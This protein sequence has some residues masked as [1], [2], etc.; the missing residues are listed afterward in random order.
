MAGSESYKWD[1]KPRFRRGAFGPRSAKAVERVKQAVAEI[2]LVARREPVLAAEGAVAF[3]E[4]VSAALEYVD[5]SSGAIGTAVNKAIDEL[6]PIISAAPVEN[7]TRQAWLER[8]FSAHEMEDIPYIDLLAERWGELCASPELAS[9]WADETLPLTREVVKPGRR[10]GDFYHGDEICLS[11]LFF[12]GRYQEIVD[13]VGDDCYWSCRRWV[14]R[15]LV[16]LG[17]KAEAIRYAET[18][19]GPYSPGGA[20]DG[21]CEGVL[22]SS[23]LVEEAYRRYGLT[24]NG[25]QTNLATFRAVAKK[26][27]HKAPATI[28]ADLATTTP[29]TEGKWFAAA[30]SARLYDLALDLARRSA[31]DLRVMARA[32]RDHK[33]AQPAFALGA[34]MLA[35]KWIAAGYGWDLSRVDVWAVVRDTL[36]AAAH[37]GVEEETRRHMRELLAGEGQVSDE[38]RDMLAQLVGLGVGS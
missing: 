36:E 17:R 1:F 24:A 15:A 16:A 3:L 10:L 29:G 4:R 5:S 37:L 9:W 23:G 8:L 26:Y 38:L 7:G 28:L 11:S 2:K 22:L 30:T 33:K 27:P 25:R 6:A 35:L 12:A 21:F 31:P 20:I 34:G 14:A 19:R 32:V 18:C 13:L